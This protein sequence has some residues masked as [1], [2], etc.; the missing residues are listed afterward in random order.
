MWSK[1]ILMGCLIIVLS[2]CGTKRKISSNVSTNVVVLADGFSIHNLDYH[3]FNGRAKS[4]IE[5]GDEKQD[6]TLHIRMEK[7]KAIWMSITATVVNYEAAR[8]LITPD[9]VKIMNKMHSEY[10]AKP[11][12]YINKYTGGGV[13]FNILQ[14][15]LL[16]NVNKK[17]LRTDQLTIAS[18]G[19]D[20][21]LVG[22]N[23]GLDF[24]YSLN[25]NKRPKVFRLSA[26]KSDEYLEAFY[27]SYAEVTGY[28][29][30]QNQNVNLNANYLTLKALIDYNKVEF[31]EPVEMPFVVPAKYKLIN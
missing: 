3:T 10:I 13:D 7:D 26:K 31:N 29:F 22:F 8:I 27:G 5:F 14:D 23:N 16:A 25:E 11:F 19:E 28:N 24:Q 4:K 1:L 12:D 17:L 15:V 2:S 6:F 21:Q 20:T 30:P 9:S 18:S